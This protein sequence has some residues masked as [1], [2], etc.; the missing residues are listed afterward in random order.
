MSSIFSKNFR[1]YKFTCHKKHWLIFPTAK[2]AR[3][4]GGINYWD[5]YYVHHSYNWET[6]KNTVSVSEEQQQHTVRS[7]AGRIQWSST[8]V[9]EVE[10]PEYF[11]TMCLIVVG[12]IF[13]IKII[14]MIYIFGNSL[15]FI[16][17]I[18]TKR[19]KILF[20]ESSIRIL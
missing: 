7:G 5:G 10:W 12:D 17:I 4:F 19:Q 18:K 1:N 11:T 15:L 20:S 13:F 6:L 16:S 2:I 14:S 8:G 3:I 9:R